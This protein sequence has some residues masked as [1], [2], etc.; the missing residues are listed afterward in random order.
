MTWYPDWQ[1]AAEHSIHDKA[2]S[3][4]IEMIHEARVDQ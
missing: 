3:E 1:E 4:G 2:V